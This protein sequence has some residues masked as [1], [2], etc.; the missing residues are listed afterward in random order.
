MYFIVHF[1]LHIPSNEY[2]IQILSWF[3]ETYLSFWLVLRTCT[4]CTFLLVLYVL[5][6][7]NINNWRQHN[8]TRQNREH[9]C[10]PHGRSS[11]CWVACCKLRSTRD[12]HPPGKTEPAPE[13]DIV[14]VAV[15]A[16]SYTWHSVIYT[17]YFM[18]MFTCTICTLIK[19]GSL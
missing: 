18:Y 4:I 15:S 3:K 19:S 14:T 5:V 2:N 16:L 11:H 7:R 9:K 8:P 10:F 13:T 1:I 17:S 6:F 12:H